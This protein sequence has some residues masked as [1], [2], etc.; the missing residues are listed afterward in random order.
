MDAVH[1][2]EIHS[3]AQWVKKVERPI[4]KTFSRSKWWKESLTAR[5]IKVTLKEAGLLAV[6]MTV[7]AV[8]VTIETGSLEKGLHIAVIAG[9]IKA[10]AAAMYGRLVG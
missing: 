8:V 2:N 4:S 7:T 10:G 1:R 3:F 6:M 9:P 5:I